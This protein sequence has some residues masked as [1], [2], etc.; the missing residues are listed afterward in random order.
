MMRRA[1]HSAPAASWRGA[2]FGLTLACSLPSLHAA[3]PAAEASGPLSG[4]NPAHIAS[5]LL[6]PLKAP[7]PSEL[8]NRGT[9]LSLIATDGYAYIEV[10]EATGSRWLAAPLVP[11]ATGDTIAYSDGAVVA[12][13]YSKSLK[14]NFQNLLFA[15]HVVVVPSPR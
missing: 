12:D 2:L 8:P 4:A 7:P 6:M 1:L 10:R 5:D 3:P 14:R 15:D 9:V 11:M 13:F